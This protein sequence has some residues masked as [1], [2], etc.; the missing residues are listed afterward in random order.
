M[1]FKWAIFTTIT[2]MGENDWKS[3]CE[4][5]HLSNGSFFPLPITLATSDDTRKI[6]QKIKLVDSTNYPLCFIEVSE[7]FKPDIDKCL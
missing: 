1:Y 3:V 2:F 4:D 7:I 5:L 6:G